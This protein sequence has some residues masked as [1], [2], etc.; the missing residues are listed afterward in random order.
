MTAGASRRHPDAHAARSPRTE[1]PAQPNALTADAI[2][3][4]TRWLA[5][6]LHWFDEIDS[7]NKHA[8]AI[9]AAGAAH[10]EAV[11]AE[12]QSAG[13]GR[14]GRGFYSPPRTNLY[15]SF[16][17]RPGGSA[18]AL[19][20]LPLTAG[21]ALAEVVADELGDPTRVQLKWPNDV[22]ADEKKVSGI[23]LERAGA[24]ADSAVI[25][26]IGVNLNVDP[27]TFP[28]EFRAR[29]SSLSALAGRAIERARFAAALFERLE[30][31]LDAHA[32]R[33][34]AALRPRFDALFR[35]NDRRVRVADAA[36]RV[37]EG[38]VLGVGADGSLRLGTYAG[39]ERL[40]AGDVTLLKEPLS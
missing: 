28:D 16:V 7:T 18:A 30:A 39:E 19:G 24:S 32:E 25:L 3:A 34:F 10:G 23:L 29:A 1:S 21:V 20:T 6:T 22:L 27:A 2:A 38:V 35:M 4:R 31:A 33:G 5:R 11:I 40:L 14:L 37:T 13:R 9:A 12:A 36:G 8:L 15:V 26:G 17:L